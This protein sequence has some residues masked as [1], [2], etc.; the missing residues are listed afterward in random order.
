[1]ELV[2]LEE[3]CLRRY[4]AQINVDIESFSHNPL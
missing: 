1:M 2:I 3:A 4:T